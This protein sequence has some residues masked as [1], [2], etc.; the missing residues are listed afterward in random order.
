LTIPQNSNETTSSGEHQESWLGRLL[1]PVYGLMCLA[2]LT[3]WFFHAYIYFTNPV[4]VD[5]GEG[6]V[7]HFALAMFHGAPIYIDHTQ[8]P[9]WIFPYMPLQP[10]LQSKLITSIPPIAAG[11]I[12]SQGAITVLCAALFLYLRRFGLRA[13][14][15]GVAVFLANP[16]LLTFGCFV[17]P[18]ALA[19]GLAGCGLLLADQSKSARRDLLCA[20]LL[21]LALFTKQSYWAAPLAVLFSRWRQGHGLLRFLL[22][23]GC[24]YG[25]SLAAA[26]YL[27]DGQLIKTL[28]SRTMLGYSVNQAVQLTTDYLPFLMVPL[29]LVLPTLRKAPPIWQGFFCLSL[30]MVVGIGRFGAIHN[31]F[32]ELHLALSVLCAWSYQSWERKP[33][34][35]DLVTIGH[36]TLPVGLI[37]IGYFVSIQAIYLDEFKSW[38]AGRPPGA[39]SQAYLHHNMLKP[40]MDSRPQTIITENSGAVVLYGHPLVYFE[41]STYLGLIEQ[42]AYD[43]APILDLLDKGF[44]DLLILDNVSSNMRFSPKFMEHA[45]ANYLEVVSA[46][47]MH[48]LVPRGKVEM[49]SKIISDGMKATEAQRVEQ[50]R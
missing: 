3:C 43:E 7:T 49:Y 30:V 22:C 40:L 16:V 39:F 35:I 41:P 36:L 20:V 45:R 9:Y 21:V 18:D 38:Q 27:T 50:S 33:A 14:F 11:R 25:M 37:S 4:Q 17:R 28:T 15:I 26:A 5:Y 47:G 8:P 10:W 23:F 24:I 1:T 42:K 29:A 48:V 31:Y 34:G 2:L 6:V 44:V 46:P 13:A 32:L 19:L 12:L